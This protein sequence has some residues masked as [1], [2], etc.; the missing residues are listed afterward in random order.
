MSVKR[1]GFFDGSIEEEQDG[2]YIRHDDVVTM[3]RDVWI[4]TAIP[5]QT[6][7]AIDGARVDGFEKACV[8]ILRRLGEKT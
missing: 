2:V 7:K 4:N 1:Y 8:E 6:D 3:V 5:R